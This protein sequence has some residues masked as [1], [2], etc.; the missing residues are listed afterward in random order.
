MYKSNDNV[1]IQT[2]EGKSA[3]HEAIEVL[4]NTA[5]L[6]SI[7]PNIFLEKAAFDHQKDMSSTGI[8]GHDGSDKSTTQKIVLRGI[9]DGLVP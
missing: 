8:L 3:V 4:K 5:P 9:V 1:L 2:V 6:P 7:E